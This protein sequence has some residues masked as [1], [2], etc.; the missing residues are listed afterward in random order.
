MRMRALLP[1]SGVQAGASVLPRVWHTGA[2]QDNAVKWLGSTY[3]TLL[4]STQLATTQTL[5]PFHEQEGDPRREN[6]VD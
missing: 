5:G 1:V 6:K 4:D 2:T 3:A